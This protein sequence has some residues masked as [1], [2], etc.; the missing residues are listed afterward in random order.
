MCV[1]LVNVISNLYIVQTNNLQLLVRMNGFHT[2]GSKNVHK[3]LLLQLFVCSDYFNMTVK[4]RHK[5]QRISLRKHHA[6]NCVMR[7]NIV[8][9]N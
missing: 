8:L 7:V 1:A 9:H 3:Y 4:E 5:T 2:R 6:I